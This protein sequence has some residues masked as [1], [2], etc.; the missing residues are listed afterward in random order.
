M[1]A[2]IELHKADEMIQKVFK[3]HRF[4]WENPE[5]WMRTG[6]ELEIHY[7]MNYRS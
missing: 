5:T 7:K 1:H 2:E 6:K 3:T 4:A